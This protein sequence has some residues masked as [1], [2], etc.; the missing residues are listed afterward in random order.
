MGKWTHLV[1]HIM[2]CPGQMSTLAPPWIHHWVPLIS[3]AKARGEFRHEAQGV[4]LS[5]TSGWPPLG[6][7][8]RDAGLDQP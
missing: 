1:S 8:K 2:W 5:E 3:K 7:G 4:D 6:G